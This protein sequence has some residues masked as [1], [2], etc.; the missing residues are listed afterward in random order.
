MKKH[1]LAR[2]SLKN[3]AALF[4]FAMAIVLIAVGLM[5]LGT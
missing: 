1:K 3:T 2:P 4:F 5:S